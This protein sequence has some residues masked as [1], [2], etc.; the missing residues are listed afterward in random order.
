MAIAAPIPMAPAQLVPLQALPEETLLTKDQWAILLAICDTYISQSKA[1]TTAPASDNGG[2]SDH[3]YKQAV[4]TL[5]PMLSQD[6]KKNTIESYF[7]ESASSIPS[8]RASLQR[9]LACHVPADGQQGISTILAAMNTRAGSLLLTGSTT[10]FHLQSFTART[11]ILRAWSQSYLPPLRK[12]QRSLVALTKKIWIGLSPTLPQ[13]IGFP[14]VPAH[15]SRKDGFNFDFI[16]FEAADDPATLETDVVIVGSGCGAGVCAANLAEAGHRVLVVEKSYH[17]PT[18]HFPMQASDSGHHLFENGGAI[19]SDDGSMAVLAGSTWGGGG[20]VNWSASLQPQSFVRKEWAAG[21]GHGNE[22]PFFTSAEYQ[23][24]LDRVCERMGVSTKHIDH[25]FSNR[26]LLEGARRLGMSAIEVPQNTAGETHYCGYC[27]NGCASAT[28]QGPADRWLP[29][30]AKAGAR[31][32]EGMNVDKIL[33]E[34]IKGVK[35]A[36]GITG[37]WKSRDRSSSRE[38]NVKAKRVIVSCGTLQSPLL[39]MRSGVSNPQLG[40]N[41]HLHPV[42]ALGA[43]W[44]ERINPWE[45]GILT[46]AITALEDLDG[47]GHGAKIEIIASTPSYLLP[48]MPWRGAVQFKQD[49]AKFAHMTG[50]FSI[51]RDRDT[52]R[53]YPDPVDGRCRIA[54]TPSAFDAAHVL[55]G[56][57]AAAKVA[58]V[59]GAIEIES[60]H[61][62]MPRYI[63]PAK[64]GNVD[65]MDIGINDAG[66][67]AWLAQLRAKGISAPDPCTFGTAHQMG[68]CRMSS[69]PKKGV[70]NPK[71]K[72]W[73]ADGL[74]VADASVFP[75]A[76]GVNPMVSNMGIA[77]WISKCVDRDLNNTVEEGSRV[78]GYQTR[79]P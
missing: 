25:N 1:K 35:K 23:A 58:F 51:V 8:F 64:S 29:D 2:V 53:V 66:F 9:T 26:A 65:E 77:D 34:T 37:V 5:S 13:M 6:V 50:F 60:F 52:G 46:S 40:Q 18:S 15:G 68:T 38:V 32:V 14:S 48:F 33:F 10:P 42:S 45:G 79:S 49:V 28:K 21:D 24:S 63:R 17:Y 62:D 4:S 76:S 47:H 71:G 41:L 61:P 54:Y 20:T 27:S 55:E 39:L 78:L 3:E 73:G 70:V 67:Q 36:T 16:T 31:F 44:P 56:Q 57:L 12:L 43:V 69:N 30:A 59:M 75:S 74:Y 22:L 11:Q 19:V 72:V 7:S